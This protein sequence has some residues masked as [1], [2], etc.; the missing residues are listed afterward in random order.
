M[1]NHAIDLVTR[2]LLPALFS[3]AAHAG[4]HIGVG[5]HLVP[6]PL[7]YEPPPAYYSPHRHRCI[8]DPAWWTAKGGG[9]TAVIAAGAAVVGHMT[10]GTESTAGVVTM[11]TP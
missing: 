9:I 5:I 10:A 3:M 2:T 6:P 4:I 11:A 8:T 7:Y 1:K